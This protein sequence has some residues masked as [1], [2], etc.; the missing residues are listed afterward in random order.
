MYIRILLQIEQEVA[1]IIGKSD[2]RTHF[3]TAWTSVYVPALLLLGERSKKK[4]IKDQACGIRYM[5]MYD[6]TY[7]K[8]MHVTCTWN[9]SYYAGEG[10][11]MMNF[12]TSRNLHLY[13]VCMFFCR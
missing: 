11:F 7:F 5:C 13:N 1:L 9:P 12:S 3:E 2:I 6:H 4:G 10:G 8:Y